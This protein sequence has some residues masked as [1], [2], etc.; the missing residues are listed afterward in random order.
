VGVVFDALVFS[1]NGFWF[2]DN[3]DIVDPVV[4]EMNVQVGVLISQQTLF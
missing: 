4:V 3:L 1:A 2:F